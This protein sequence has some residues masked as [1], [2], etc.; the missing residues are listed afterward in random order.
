M[1]TSRPIRV[2]FIAAECEPWAK[3]GGL[4]DVVDALARAL[5]QVSLDAAG[6]FGGAGGLADLVDVYLPNY[7]GIPVP[8]G[9]RAVP[10]SVADP[11]ASTGATD[12]RILVVETHGYRLH[13]VD[14]APAF[15]RDG[16]YGPPGD[17]DH[18]DNAWRFGL[19]SRAAM[20][21]LRRGGSTGTPPDVIHIHDWHTGP[22]ALL[23]DTVYRSDPALRRAAL[24]LTVHNL[25]YHGW[26]PP[27]RVA[28]L[29]LS[30]TQLAT[31][32]ATEGIDLLRA[33]VTRADLV[34]TVSPGFAREALTP[35]FGMGLD[36]ELRARG[37]RFFGILNG[38]DT[39]LWNP[40]TDPALPATYS[41]ENRNGK[42]EC[43][44]GL[45]TEIG[46]DASDPRP[47]LAMIGR[48]DRQKGFDLLADAAPALLA[49]GFRL[50]VLG[51]GS[52][53]VVEPLRAVAESPAGNGKIA[54]LERFDRDLARRMYAGAD[55]FVMPSRFEPC[56]T[57]Q[58]V[59]LRYGTPPIVRAT[60]GLRDTVVDVDADP[61][62]GTGFVF[63]GDNPKA[64]VDACARFERRRTASG[65]TWEAFLDRGMAVDFD[66][67]SSSAPA[68][69]DAYRRAIA[70]RT[71]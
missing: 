10:L 28:E 38:L 46:L 51:S 45:L 69:L 5:G 31:V 66:W 18:P 40:A 63:E 41:R 20:E 47:V 3:T 19:L 2:A 54:L 44:S 30:T 39:D 59:A 17:G 27:D 42:G 32:G 6:G 21:H 71:A 62:T 67:R 26:T 14:H 9:A 11:L 43:R 58:M 7:R 8:D 36:A 25:A 55:G 64:L 48:L 22:V 4:A 12:L 61:A 34:N 50:A 16:L 60:G 53:D 56:G 1:P 33:A 15:D 52:H 29:G 35:E 37:H 68:Y 65:A 49:R 13:L 24:V 70:L 23:R 57:G